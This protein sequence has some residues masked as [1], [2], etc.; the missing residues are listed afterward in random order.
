MI[1]HEHEITAAEDRRAFEEALKANPLETLTIDSIEQNPWHAVAHGL[2]DDASAELAAAVVRA[3]DDLGERATQ[4][5][6]LANADDAREHWLDVAEL[7]QMRGENAALAEHELAARA[8]WREPAFS[9]ATIEADPW[10]AVHL[11]IPDKAEPELLALARDWASDLER[12]AEVDGALSQPF[13]NA[14]NYTREENVIAAAERVGVLDGQ[15]WLANERGEPMPQQQQGQSHSEF[16]SG[17]FIAS[18]AGAHLART[19]EM[20]LGAVLGYFVPEPELTPEQAR[21]GQK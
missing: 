14:E 21:T 1:G 16:L 6:E 20:L 10:T 13:V 5:A 3:T 7:A 17:G 19:V 15:L 8:A 2:P 4:W 18:R 9:R 12:Y 11:P